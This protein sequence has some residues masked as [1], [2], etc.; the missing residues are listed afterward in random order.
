MSLRRIPRPRPRRV[1]TE[2]LGLLGLV[3]LGVAVPVSPAGAAT[4]TP[5]CPLRGATVTRASTPFVAT[6]T[7]RRGTRRWTV[8]VTTTPL[9]CVAQGRISVGYIT[10]V[11][12]APTRL[13]LAELDAA[14]FTPLGMS[15]YGVATPAKA[16]VARYTWATP[17]SL[18]SRSR[19][20]LAYLGP[21]PPGFDTQPGCVSTKAAPAGTCPTWTYGGTNS[22]LGPTWAM[23]SPMTLGLPTLARGTY[24]LRLRFT[25]E[26]GNSIAGIVT[27]GTASL[28][29]IFKVS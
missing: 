2:A 7:V 18:W 15:S 20:D 24:V 28:S 9:A 22:L 5:S 29:V 21:Q 11:T 4:T 1:R 10:T 17:V 26:S 16:S 25:L 12:G 3:L 19:L 27:S 23:S 8:K 13:T 6:G 14:V